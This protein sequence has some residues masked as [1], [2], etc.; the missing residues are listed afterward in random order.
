MKQKKHCMKLSKFS[1]LYRYF[2]FMDTPQ[3]LADQLFIKHQVRVH[4]MEEYGKTGSPYLV[5]FCK[6]LKRDEDKFLAALK[7]LPNKMLLL[8]HTDYS[9]TLEAFLNAKP[10]PEAG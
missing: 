3:Y 7:E 9:E 6:V 10:I 8:G 1:L 2:V 5:I 4:F